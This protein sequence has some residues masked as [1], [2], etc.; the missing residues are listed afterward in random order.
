MCGYKSPQNALAGLA[1]YQRLGLGEQE[2]IALA[3]ECSPSVLLVNDNQAR[4]V[5]ARVGVNVVN[6]P[7]FLLACKQSQVLDRTELTAIIADLQTKDFYTFRQDV[8][9]LLMS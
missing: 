5:A 3:R 2:A 4:R 9:A 8:L 7:A 6:I 1:E